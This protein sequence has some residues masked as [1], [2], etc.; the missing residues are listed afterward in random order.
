MSVSEAIKT[1]HDYCY[2]NDHCSD[3]KLEEF[4]EDSGFVCWVNKI[5]D[6]DELKEK[7]KKYEL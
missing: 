5:V 7:V 3:C 6:N 2:S 4:R 1:L